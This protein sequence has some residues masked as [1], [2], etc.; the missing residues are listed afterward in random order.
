M[1]EFDFEK[2]RDILVCPVSHARLVLHG[3]MLVSTDP[4]TR[5][6]YPIDDNIPR[7]LAD[8]GT[9]LSE[10]D[11]QTVMQNQSASQSQNSNE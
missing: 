11:W 5:L 6:S 9:P 3:E 10:S 4:E 7:L 1:S 8:Y 2:L